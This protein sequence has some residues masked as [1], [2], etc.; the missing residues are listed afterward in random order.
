MGCDIHCYAE[1][2]ENGVW[3]GITLEERNSL[4]D[5]DWFSYADE[6][7]IKE[8]AKAT[9][10]EGHS[11]MLST[12]PYWTER[13]RMWKEGKV[14]Q[15]VEETEEEE[16]VDAKAF[17]IEVGR[18]YS[19]FSILADVRNYDDFTP[20]SQPKGLPQDVT[21]HIKALSDSY[22]CDGH[23]HSYISMQEFKD[24]TKEAKQ[25]TKTGIV[26]VKEFKNYVE[27]GEPQEWCGGIS[28]TNVRMVSEDEMMEIYKSEVE[29]HNAYCKIS[30]KKWNL[31]DIEYF[32]ENTAEPMYKLADP[33]NVRI[34]FWF[35]N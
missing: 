20:I 3:R 11:R 15:W 25:E 5:P 13:K 7:E 21:E 17:E 29:D 16:I 10:N 24:F 4:P 30:W 34:V 6:E 28:G 22:G 27:T 32:I 35:D 18:N 26:S 33:E 2:K 12:V 31:K 9:G 1:I 19:L 8:R 14:D 23:S